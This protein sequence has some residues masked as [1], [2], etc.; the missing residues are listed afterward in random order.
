[1][2]P[3]IG[4][5]GGR[6]SRA[7]RTAPPSVIPLTPHPLPGRAGGIAG[8]P[9]RPWALG[10]HGAP[11]DRRPGHFAIGPAGRRGPLV[12]G[13]SWQWYLLAER[14]DRHRTAADRPLSASP[15]E[16]RGPSTSLGPAG[17]WVL[18]SVGPARHRAR[19]SSAAND[20]GWTKRHPWLPP[21]GD[22]RTARGPAFNSA[23]NCGAPASRCCRCTCS[24][25]AASAVTNAAL[26]ADVL[27][28]VRLDLP[29][30][31]VPPGR[32]ALQPAAGR[33]CGRWPWTAH[34]DIHRPGR[35]G[36][37]G[38]TRIGRAAAAGRRARPAGHRA[39]A[40]WPR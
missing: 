38:P 15:R 31:A 18:A 8:K 30:C 27:R 24:A 19:A 23:G 14:A 26:A 1:M 7:G 9:P 28:D 5:H 16:P 34:A 3:G 20:H 40:G 12:E 29:A 11:L 35:G 37:A 4:A 21:P 36:R 39:S 22:R 25:A 17:H 10:A 32:S 2:A 6:P 13:A 33:P